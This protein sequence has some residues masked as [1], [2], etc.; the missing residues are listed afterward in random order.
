MFHIGH[1]VMFLIVDSLPEARDSILVVVLIS[2]TVIYQSTLITL[3]V[4]LTASPLVKK[5]VHGGDL[6][7]H[8]AP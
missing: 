1:R 5:L 4:Y 8:K 7:T 6:C 2:F 3:K